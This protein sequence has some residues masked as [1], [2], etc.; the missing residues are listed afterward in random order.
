MLDNKGI[1]NT[2][3]ISPGIIS[4]CH[5]FDIPLFEGGEF[6]LVTHHMS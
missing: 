5:M 3:Y 6:E 4:K 2:F 1:S